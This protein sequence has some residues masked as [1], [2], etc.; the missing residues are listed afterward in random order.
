MMI[1][2]EDAA[3]KK[4]VVAMHKCEHPIQIVRLD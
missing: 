4:F 2:I 3:L 1:E